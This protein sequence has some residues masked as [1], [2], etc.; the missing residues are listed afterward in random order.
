MTDAPTTPP[1][2]ATG[3]VTR[4]T[5][6]AAAPTSSDNQDKVD[7]L[8]RDMLPDRLS[9]FADYVTEEWQERRTQINQ[10]YAPPCST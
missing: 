8:T 3:R 5:A 9:R 1:T 4:S 6:Q 7:Y 10:R 2:A